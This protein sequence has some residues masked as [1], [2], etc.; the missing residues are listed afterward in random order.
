[1]NKALWDKVLGPM[2]S[3]CFIKYLDV[4]VQGIL[5]RFADDT[6]LGRIVAIS[7][8]DR[9]KI[10][11]DPDSLEQRAKTNKMKFNRDKCKVSHLNYKKNQAHE[12]RM[13]TTWLSSSTCEKGPRCLSES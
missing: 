11:N 5:I 3:N 6:K 1:M 12:Y 4:N 8:E 13:G 7:T 9:R 2:L 10:Q